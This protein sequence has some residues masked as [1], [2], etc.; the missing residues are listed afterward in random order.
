[1]RKQ[2]TSAR[3]FVIKDNS[4]ST[5]L[6][7]LV[8]PNDSAF[9]YLEV[10]KGGSGVFWQAQKMEQYNLCFANI[11]NVLWY[12]RRTSTCS[13]A[14]FTVSVINENGNCITQLTAAAKSGNMEWEVEDAGQIISFHGQTI[15]KLPSYI[16]DNAIITLSNG[17]ECSVTKRLGDDASFA[18]NKAA[19]ANGKIAGLMKLILLC[20]LILQQVFSTAGKTGSY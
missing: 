19:C 7:R 6:P 17:N 9:F 14:D 10:P 18:K 1:M 4:G 2:M 15:V 12:A 16:S 3:P 13:N 8:I 20:T 5:L 11:S